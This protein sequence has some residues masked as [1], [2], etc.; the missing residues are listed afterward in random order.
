MKRKL[1]LEDYINFLQ[2]TQ[3]ENK[4]SCLKKN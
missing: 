2:A 4:M 1:K 3:L